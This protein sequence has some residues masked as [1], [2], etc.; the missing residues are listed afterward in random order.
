MWCTLPAILELPLREEGA[1]H[2][3]L[4][5]S[6]NDEDK[7]K[8]RAAISEMRLFVFWH[9]RDVRCVVFSV[10]SLLSLRCRWLS[11]RVFMLTLDAWKAVLLCSSIYAGA[12]SLKDSESTHVA[13]PCLP[14]AFKSFIG[15]GRG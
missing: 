9:G 10:L 11:G 8:I 12:M 2:L 3:Q 15:L 6:G 13:L 1:T 4:R 14:I 7:S 5:E